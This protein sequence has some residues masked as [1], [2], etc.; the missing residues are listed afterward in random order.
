MLQENY[1]RL[2]DDPD[3]MR[4]FKNECH[5]SEIGGR[6]HLRLHYR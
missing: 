6:E 3:V 5:G 1:R 4:W 2:L